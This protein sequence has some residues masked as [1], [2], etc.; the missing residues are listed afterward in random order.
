MIDKIQVDEFMSM[1]E[2]NLL[3]NHLCIRIEDIDAAEK[4]MEESF[5]ITGF[6]RPS[7]HLF[8]GEE[9]SKVTWHSNKVYW[10]L[11]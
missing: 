9:D 8:E 6:I 2:N 11:M 4:M 3:F 5:D 10:E 1:Q 7:S